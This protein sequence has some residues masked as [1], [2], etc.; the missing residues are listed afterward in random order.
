[1]Y[2]FWHTTDRSTRG[3]ILD[4]CFGF[5]NSGVGG[6]SLYYRV[7]VFSSMAGSYIYGDPSHILRRGLAGDDTVYKVKPHDIFPFYPGIY[8]LRIRCRKKCKGLVNKKTVL[9]NEKDSNG[10]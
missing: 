4:E 10:C 8:R 5:Y 6:A 2:F 9:L 1:M 3:K 7:L